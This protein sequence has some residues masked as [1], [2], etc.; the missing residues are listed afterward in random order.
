MVTQLPREDDK[1]I[2]SRDKILADLDV[3][4]GDRAAEEVIFGESKVSSLALSDLSEATDMVARYGMS[5]RVGPVSYDNDNGSWNA[6]T[7]T[8]KSTYL[9]D[10]EV[11][12]LLGKAYQNAKTILTTHSKELHVLA[13]ALLKDETL[14]GEQ[15]TALLKH[16]AL[17]GGQTTNQYRLF[18]C[19]QTDGKG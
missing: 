1:F 17:A 11:R 9:V 3:L 5:K 12:E 19:Q 7:M 15:I 6:K 16:E 10:E 8:W 18:A 4:M 13:R 14:T 2:L